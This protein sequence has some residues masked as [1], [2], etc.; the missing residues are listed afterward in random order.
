MRHC[1][2]ALKQHTLTAVSRRL[3]NWTPAIQQ[4]SLSRLTSSFAIVHWNAPDYLM[5]NVRRLAVF[6]P[7]QKSMSRQLL[8]P[9]QPV[10]KSYLTAFP[11]F[12]LR[13]RNDS[14]HAVGLQFFGAVIQPG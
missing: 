10:P 6:I 1:P 14:E 5:L 3:K 13:T 8:Y 4:A 2:P 12:S 9:G 7:I 11:Q